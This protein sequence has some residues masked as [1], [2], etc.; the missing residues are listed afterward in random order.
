MPA[1]GRPKSDMPKNVQIKIRAD[2]QT[3]QDLVYCSDKLDISKSDVIRLGIQMV[4]EMVD[5]KKN[6]SN[7]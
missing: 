3:L 2:F 7:D 1:M 6:N 4:K 5:N